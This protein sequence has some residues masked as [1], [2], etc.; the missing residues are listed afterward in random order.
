MGKSFTL[1]ET[2]LM[3]AACLL[4]AALVCALHAVNAVRPCGT[5]SAQSAIEAAADESLVPAVEEIFV[6]NGTLHIAGYLAKPGRQ[7]GE[8]R[9]RFGLMAGDKIVLLNTQMVRRPDIAQ[10]LGCEVFCGAHAAAKCSKIAD[11][12]YEIVFVDAS[13]GEPQ[14]LRTGQRIELSGGVMIAGGAA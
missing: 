10:T 2:L 5:I 3:L 9:V 6:R 12:V 11:G 1:R 8:V 13:D 14:L 7:L 4:A